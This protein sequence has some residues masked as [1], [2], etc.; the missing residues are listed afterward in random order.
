M[1]TLNS[2]VR[3]LEELPASVGVMKR[4]LQKSEG[5]GVLVYEQLKGISRQ[6][7]FK[8]K[9]GIA[10][11]IPKEGTKS[12]HWICLLPRR[13]H[14]EY[15]SPLGQS[16]ATELKQLNQAET[17][18]DRLSG[19]KFIYNRTKLQS[20]DYN[21]K[22]CSQFVFARLMLYK[23]KLREFVTLFRR[24]VHLESPDEIVSMLCLLPFSSV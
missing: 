6:A 21:I 8:N 7:L 12:G 5:F 2:L 17:H 20:G 15:F 18:F 11:L 13:N 23:L 9:K 24:D 14:L 1:V 16:F 10:V 3:E 4:L 19:G 22:T